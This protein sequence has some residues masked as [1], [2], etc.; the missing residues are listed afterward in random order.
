MP[1]GL[2]CSMMSKGRSNRATDS[3]HVRV[4]GAL[5][6][7]WR[8]RRPLCGFR[9]GVHAVSAFPDVGRGTWGPVPRSRTDL[10]M[11]H[12]DHVAKRGLLEYGESMGRAE[13]LRRNRGEKAAVAAQARAGGP[14]AAVCQ[15]G[16]PVVD[17]HR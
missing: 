17:L 7:S 9:T 15:P 2:E 12:P 10:S 8:G 4:V 16:R 1:N 14:G 3:L 6:I 13:R 5:S 11:L